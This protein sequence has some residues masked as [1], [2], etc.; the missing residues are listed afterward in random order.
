MTHCYLLILFYF[1]LFSNVFCILVHDYTLCFIGSPCCSVSY[2]NYNS[3]WHYEIVIHIPQV[4]NSFTNIRVGHVTFTYI[5]QVINSRYYWNTIIPLSNYFL[6]LIDLLC[7][8]IF[9]S[10]IIRLPNN[11]WWTSHQHM[12]VDMFIGVHGHRGGI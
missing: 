8:N 11:K 5:T 10:V 9:N 12:R 1:I 7:A 6:F 2:Y 3:I 4:I